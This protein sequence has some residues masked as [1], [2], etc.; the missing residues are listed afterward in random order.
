MPA[1]NCSLPGDASGSDDVAEDPGSGASEGP[2][3]DD[4]EAPEGDGDGSGEEL[5]GPCDSNGDPLE[6]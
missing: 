1:V 2:A 4:P 5:L 6:G 3:G